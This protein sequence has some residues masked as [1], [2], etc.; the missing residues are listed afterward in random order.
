MPRARPRC[1]NWPTVRLQIHSSY[2]LPQLLRRVQQQPGECLAGVISQLPFQLLC[3]GM[4]LVVPAV[5]KN[6]TLQVQ[7]VVEGVQRRAQSVHCRVAG[8]RGEFRLE[9]R[10]AGN[11]IG[12]K[13]FPLRG[14]VQQYLTGVCR[15]GFPRQITQRLEFRGDGADRLLADI[16]YRRHLLDTAAAR[17]DQGENLS[18][19]QPELRMAALARELHKAV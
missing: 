17:A 16:L 3:Q 7:P 10:Y 4:D 1:C 2:S 9:V 19:T 12:D 8:N 15:I 14:E 13:P 6:T 11:G 5:F 18:V